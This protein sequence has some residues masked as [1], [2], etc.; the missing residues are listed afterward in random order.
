MV[1]CKAA[2]NSFAH[3]LNL[4]KNGNKKDFIEH[5]AECG[6]IFLEVRVSKLFYLG[7]GK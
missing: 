5:S 6:R 2:V 3:L 4:K 1:L 7:W